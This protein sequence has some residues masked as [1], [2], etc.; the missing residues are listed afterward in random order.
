MKSNTKKIVTEAMLFI[1][2]VN[3]AQRYGLIVF[4]WGD[5]NNN[6]DTIKLLKD[7]GLQA[8]IY[9]KLD[10]LTSKKDKVK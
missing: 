5:D 1:S 2:K 8:I 3:F 9:D 7:L 4:S 6:K 10:L